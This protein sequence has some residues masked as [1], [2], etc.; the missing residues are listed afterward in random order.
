MNRDLRRS[1]S[2][3]DGSVAAPISSRGFILSDES[4]EPCAV[5]QTSFLSDDED[6]SVAIAE[7]SFDAPARSRTNFDDDI[8]LSEDEECVEVYPTELKSRTSW[9]I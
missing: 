6:G 9:M 3:S 1:Q 2:E 7:P 8:E 5:Q 4:D